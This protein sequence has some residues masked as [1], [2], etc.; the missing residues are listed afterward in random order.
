LV[1][2]DTNVSQITQMH[3]DKIVS[4][5]L[6]AICEKNFVSLCVLMFR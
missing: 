6:T 2:I 3:T 4:V 1:T 5:R